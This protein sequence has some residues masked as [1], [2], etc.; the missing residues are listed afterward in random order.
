MISRRSFL[1]STA[2]YAAAS[3]QIAA[4]EN[5]SSDDV[6]P[7]TISTSLQKRDYCNQPFR[8]GVALGDSVTAGGTATSR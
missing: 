5:S 2:T 3:L 1:D 7:L 8:I 6:S 4:G